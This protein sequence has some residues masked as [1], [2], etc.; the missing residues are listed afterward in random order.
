[1]NTSERHNEF[2]RDLETEFD[3]TGNLTLETIQTEHDDYVEAPAMY[4][5]MVS[6]TA[7]PIIRSGAV[8]TGFSWSHPHGGRIIASFSEPVALCGATHDADGEEI[9]FPSRAGDAARAIL[10]KLG[11]IAGLDDTGL[12]IYAA[13]CEFRT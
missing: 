2:I 7:H 10:A 5:D 4:G 3:M 9:E 12:P 13:E 6:Y 1:M 11:N 8:L